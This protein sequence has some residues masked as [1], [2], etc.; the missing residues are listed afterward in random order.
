MKLIKIYFMV[1]V[2]FIISC[3]STQSSDKTYNTEKSAVADSTAGTALETITVYGLI[4]ADSENVF[5]VTNWKSRSMVTYTVT[6]I[7]KSELAENSGK[8]TSVSGVLIKKQT[9]SGTLEVKNINSID[10]SPDPRKEKV[11]NF[12]KK[13]PGK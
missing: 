9:R 6:G 4:K 3:Y 1:S 12:M 13:K 7:K 2:I 5:I 11:F 10:E 8:Y